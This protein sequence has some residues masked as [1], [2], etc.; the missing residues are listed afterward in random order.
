MLTENRPIVVW[1]RRGLT[2][3]VPHASARGEENVL[4]LDYVAGFTGVCTYQNS[5]NCTLKMNLLYDTL[6]TL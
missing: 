5:Y 2:T 3:E 6:I 1:G 4:P